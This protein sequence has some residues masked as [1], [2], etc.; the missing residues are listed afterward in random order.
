MI[1]TS[2]RGLF[3]NE[4]NL[5]EIHLKL[6]LDVYFLSNYYMQR[7]NNEVEKIFLFCN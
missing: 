2:S 7:L 3:I 1:S 6:T 4:L 5:A